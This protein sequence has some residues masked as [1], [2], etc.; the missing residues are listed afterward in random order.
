MLVGN[1]QIYYKDAKN[2]ESLKKW[3]NDK[4]WKFYLFDY[5]Q[6]KYIKYQ[7]GRPQFTKRMNRKK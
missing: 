4:G 2:I 1:R 7:D 3:L 6:M 5:D